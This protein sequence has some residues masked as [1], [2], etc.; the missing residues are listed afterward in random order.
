MLRVGWRR[1]L[2]WRHIGVTRR[3]IMETVNWIMKLRNRR[4]CS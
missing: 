3:Q 2:L 1:R 4:R